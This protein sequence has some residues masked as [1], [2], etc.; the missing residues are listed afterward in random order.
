MRCRRPPWSEP[1]SHSRQRPPPRRSAFRNSASALRKRIFN[2]PDMTL[3]QMTSGLSHPPAVQN[4]INEKRKNKLTPELTIEVARR[5]YG[6]DYADSVAK[7]L[8]NP[9][10]AIA[11][12]HVE[13]KRQLRQRLKE[14]GFE[15]TPLPNRKQL[16]R[17]AIDALLNQ[18]GEGRKPS[19]SRSARRPKL[20]ERQAKKLAY[21]VPV[22]KDLVQEVLARRTDSPFV[23]RVLKDAGMKNLV[24]SSH[25]SLAKLA[26]VLSNANRSLAQRAE[27]LEAAVAR[28]TGE[29]QSL[30]E[31]GNSRGHWHAQALQL[32]EMDYTMNQIANFLGRS[33]GAVKQVL[34]RHAKSKSLS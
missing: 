13:S 1:E 4:F 29:V 6:A 31:G 15:P 32:R 9:S 10:R 11:H 30:R 12:A 23:Q 27:N 22:K 5:Q 25:T 28:L 19:A 33:P 3:A 14:L 8:A 2:A 7:A 34:A 18:L 24:I 17:E 16:V 20:S 21:N 26:G